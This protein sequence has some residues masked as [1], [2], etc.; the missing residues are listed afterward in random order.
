MFL[1]SVNYDE[2]FAMIFYTTISLAQN[3]TQMYSWKAQG[4]EDDE[5]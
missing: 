4:R 2:Q 1:S 5:N 3:L